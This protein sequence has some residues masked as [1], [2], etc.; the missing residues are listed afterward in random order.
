MYQTKLLSDTIKAKIETSLTVLKALDHE[1]RQAI[2]AEIDKQQPV[3]ASH[4]AT[5]LKMEVKEV[6]RQLNFLDKANVLVAS[7]QDTLPAF[8]LNYDRIAQIS[9]IVKKLAK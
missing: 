9:S 1:S 8:S 3:P 6:L 2:L 5:S 7:H 4:L